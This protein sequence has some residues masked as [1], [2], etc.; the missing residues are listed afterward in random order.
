MADRPTV[1]I[2]GATGLSGDYLMAELAADP[3]DANLRLVSRRAGA[4]AQL[5]RFGLKFEF[6]RGDIGDTAFLKTAMQ[7]VDIVLHIAGIRN[8]ENVIRFG[9]QAGVAQFVLIHTTSRYSTKKSRG[10]DYALIEDRIIGTYPNVTILRPTMIYGGLKD[11]NIRHLAKFISQRRVIPVFGTGQNLMQ[12]VHAQD[13]A[14]AYARILRNPGAVM[15]RQYN[16]PG[17]EPLTFDDLLREVA[18]ALGRDVR[19]V[20]IPIWAAALA[21]KLANTVAPGRGLL[22]NDQVLGLLDDKAF[23]WSDARR[24][25]GYAPR[26]F[27]DGIRDAV[28]RY[29]LARQ[30]TGQEG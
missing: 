8:S 1:L 20:H 14:R 6:A 16:L 30:Q 29:G 10:R 5:A 17:A 18:A 19:L 13:L 22:K 26:R 25:F 3:I 27:Q 11:R 9:N 24:D 23:D 2:S 7:G 21:I 15:G 4:K 12:P 28:L